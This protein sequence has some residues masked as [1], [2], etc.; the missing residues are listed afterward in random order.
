MNRG[1]EGLY[2]RQ[3][4]AV[5]KAKPDLD[6]HAFHVEI[7]GADKSHLAFTND[8]FDKFLAACKAITEP[9]NLQAQLDALNGRKKR[10][11]YG[12]VRQAVRMGVSLEY[13]GGI[14]RAMNLRSADLDVLDADEL[15]KVRIALS[16]QDR[17]GMTVKEPRR[18]VVCKSEEPF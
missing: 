17:R 15:E 10:L 4:S 3:W 8:D 12:I 6:R 5:H 2:W 14:A 16:K 9:G 11:K 13:V 18:P 7:F 1:Q